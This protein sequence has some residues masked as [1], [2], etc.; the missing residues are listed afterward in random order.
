MES[1]NMMKKIMTIDNR[2]DLLKTEKCDGKKDV[3][4]ERVCVRE[5]RGE[6]A[7]RS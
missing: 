5:K 7:S 1:D 6:E 3:E 2:N 4:K